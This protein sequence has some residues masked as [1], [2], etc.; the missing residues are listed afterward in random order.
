MLGL[1]RDVLSATHHYK[2]ILWISSDG[3]IKGFLGF[4]IFDSRT[5]LGRKICQLFFVCL[6]LSRDLSSDFLGI[7]NNMKI[8]GSTRVSRSH[9]SANKVQPNLFCSYFNI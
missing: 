8:C 5:F 9:S 1:E 4:E 2:G 6:D 7:L 3:M